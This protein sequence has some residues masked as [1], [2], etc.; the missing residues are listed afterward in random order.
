MNTTMRERIVVVGA[1]AAGMSAAHQALRSAQAAGAQIDVMV[2]EKTFDTSYSACG[3]PYLIAGLVD[4]PDDLTA[5]TAAEHRAQGI[6]LRMGV[7]ATGL[8]LAS[9]HVETDGAGRVPFDQLVLAT[10]ALPRIPEWALD[11]ESRL[12]GGVQPVKTLD[13]GRFWLERVAP[14]AR[15]GERRAVVVGGGYIG[16]EMAEAMIVLGFHTTL[17][18]RHSVMGTL[19]PEMRERILA[20]LRA[21][22][23]HV[24]TGRTIDSAHTLDGHVDSITTDDGTTYP[25][26]LVVLGI[27]VRPASDLGSQAGLPIGAHGGYLTDAEQHL[28]DGVW[29]AGDCCEVLDRLRGKPVFAPL[30]THANK[31]GRICGHNLLGDHRTFP[32]ILGTAITRFSAAD[33]HL[34]IARTGLSTAQATEAGFDAVSLVSE[35][36]TASGYMPEHSAI[37]MNVIADRATRRLLGMQIVGEANSGKRIDTAAAALWGEMSI[38][39][40]AGM[41]L[42]YAPPFATA[43]EAVQLAARRLA[44]RL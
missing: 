24:V 16:L 3:I 12:L 13:D 41:D 44:D 42:S 2:L 25:A 1:D 14:A 18:T 10:G 4:S 15:D 29:A 22:G 11:S 35:S 33:V 20:G 39:D 34:E 30:G 19:D 31:Q 36:G 26:D 27:G 17:V 28:G 43:W 7:T 5:R 32:G 40:L 23:V 21:A 38:D 9:R 6:D 37:A 8:D